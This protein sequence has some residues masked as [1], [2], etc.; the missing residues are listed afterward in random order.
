[1]HLNR[2]GR[3]RP[4][5][6]A[7]QPVVLVTLVGE[8]QAPVPASE[9]AVTDPHQIEQHQAEPGSVRVV[10]QSLDLVVAQDDHRART[11]VDH[12]RAAATRRSEIDVH[13]VVERDL[14]NRLRHARPLI[15]HLAEMLHDV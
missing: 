5:D 11:G 6:E 10:G 14:K 12:G 4:G 3:E 2:T 9:V 7:S 15:A 8:H 13:P 1:V